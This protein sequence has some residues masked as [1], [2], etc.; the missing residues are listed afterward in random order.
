[1]NK[2]TKAPDFNI[3][4]EVSDVELLRYLIKENGKTKEE[5]ATEIRERFWARED[6][7]AYLNKE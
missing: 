1:M 3:I 4:E 5:L 7:T 6:L 2:E